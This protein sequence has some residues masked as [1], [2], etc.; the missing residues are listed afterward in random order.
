M[1]SFSQRP[2]GILSFTFA[3]ARGGLCGLMVCDACRL[4]CSSYRQRALPM[5]VAATAAPAL[6][7]CFKCVPWLSSALSLGSPFSSMELWC[8]ARLEHL[9]SL[10]RRVSQNTGQP[11][12]QFSVCPL[13]PS[14]Q[15]VSRHRLLT[16]ECQLPTAV[17]L[18]PL[19]SN[20]P[21]GLIFP[22][23]GSVAGAPIGGSACSSQRADVCPAY[24][25]FL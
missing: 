21:R 22:A 12:E 23:S 14:L 13:C 17:L 15:P 24:P 7:R 6:L 19:P 2:Q 18:F 5:K 20:Q 11:L 1:N 8:E 3:G 25:S 4:R 10:G 16:N 9:L